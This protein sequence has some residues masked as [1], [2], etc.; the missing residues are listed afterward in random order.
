VAERAEKARNDHYAPMQQHQSK[1][2]PQLSEGAESSALAT[3]GNGAA[4]AKG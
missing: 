1:V 2:D 3:L 4:N